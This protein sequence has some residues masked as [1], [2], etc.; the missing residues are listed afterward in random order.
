MVSLLTFE[1]AARTLS[2][3]RA[4]EELH[5]SQA[6]VSKQVRYL[7]EFL[8]QKLFERHGRRVELSHQGRI[9]F[10]KVNS[11]FNF[12]A[13]A[14]EE[15]RSTNIS[16]TV[17]IAANNAVTHYWLGRVIER[18]KQAHPEFHASIRILSSDR[19]ADLFAEDIDMA[20]VYDPPEISGW[21]M[22]M[23]FAEELYPVASHVYIENHPLSSG[24]PEQL[25]NYDLLDYERV[26]PNWINWRIWLNAL[27]VDAHALRVASYANSYLSLVSAAEHS[28]GITLG[29]RY[30]LDEQIALGRLVRVSDFTYRSGRAYYLGRNNFRLSSADADVMHKWILGLIQ[31]GAH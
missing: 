17:T 29:T 25:L 31:S 13:D 6:A 3:T 4:S 22:E 30:L 19:T 27:G 23:L 11:C 21:S 18:F 9:L 2:F 14:V 28:Q 16:R 26:E 5:V 24:G 7:E 8:G 12:M 20:I 15:V 10:S 1:A